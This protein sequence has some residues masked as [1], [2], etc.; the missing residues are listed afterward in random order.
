MNRRRPIVLATLYLLG[1]AMLGPDAVAA[2][3]APKALNA[4]ILF[5]T[6]FPIA[7]D[8]ATIGS[9]FA[10]HRG[11]ISLSG[12]G[13]DLYI[14]YADGSLRNLTQEAG[15]GMVGLQ[16]ANAISVR[17]PEVHFSGTKAVFSMVIGAPAQFA[18]T[19][20]YYQL[21]EV[22][23]F[24]Q[25]QTVSITKVPNQP[26][27]YN[28]VQ[29]IYAS[30]G[31]LI[32]SSDR[33]RDGRRHLYPQHDEYESTATPT[34]LWKLNPATGDL[35]LLQHSPSG[36]FDPLIDS[37]GRLVFT[38]WDHLQRDQQADDPDNQ[39]FNWVSEEE[40]AAKVAP[41]EVFP[42][43]RVVPNGS[44]VNGHTL[45][46]FLPWM[47]NQD[48]TA[49]ETLNHVGRH[50]LH[51]YFNRSLETD[52][53]L[54]EFIGAVSGRV[55]PRDLNNVFHLTEH[56]TQPGRY[57]GIQ[58]PEFGTH[59]A[60][61][62]VALNGQPSLNPDQ[63]VVDYLTPESTAGTGNEGDHT[64]HYR[65]VLVMSDGSI[66][67]A[68]D[69]TRGP[70]GNNGTGTS[71]DPIYKFRIKRLAP[72]A[73]G[74]LEPVENLTPGNGI[75]KNISF[76]NPD[77]LV[78]YNGPLWELWPVEVRSRPVPV[79]TAEA[80]LA[81]PETAAF[82]AEQVSEAT[83]RQ[84]LR[85]RGL[86]VVVMRNVTT[87]DRA[88]RQQPFNLRVPGGAQTIGAT[89]TVYD[90]Q[91][92]QF[93]QGDQI[94]GIGGM[95]N[96]RAG[97]RVIAQTLHDQAVGNF[98]L[99]NAQGPAGSVPIAADGSVA[100][101]VPTRRALSWQSTAPNGTP[102]VRERFWI[103]VQPGEIRTCDGCHGVNTNNQANQPGA[104]QNSPQ[105]LRDLLARWKTLSGELFRNGFE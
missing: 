17:D 18:Q 2:P 15:F 39:N 13:G 10:N 88:D 101:F 69:P 86:A 68:H 11:G 81:A 52:P 100:A 23:G 41:V 75:S 12:R 77:Q 72:G 95:A 3:L 76:F 80:A 61:Q 24:G 36:S 37:Y 42:E 44:P 104:A 56:P 30:D 58:A 32:F 78:T 54:R 91:H 99:P 21:Y 49:E 65:N 53:N 89:G 22:T 60:G 64:G 20:Y 26:A 96:P 55:N 45:N 62:I 35:K 90:I 103:T 92:F 73:G 25:G 74:F 34:G 46:T 67:A 16:G 7:G 66:V 14:R 5:V 8:F 40:N 29:P 105:A 94:R 84:W 71:P 1:G 87:R 33:P 4:P 97:R 70:A 19:Q 79:N 48:G 102:V 27:D 47:L 98:N 93:F 6:Q 50:E 28:N 9:T 63:F 43:L 51:G 85:D 38:R 59:G 82:T 57:F 31:T 83:F